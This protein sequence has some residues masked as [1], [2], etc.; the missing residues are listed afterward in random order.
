MTPSRRLLPVFALLAASAC[1]S[2][3]APFGGPSDVAGAV[4]LADVDVPDAARPFLLT[5]YPTPQRVNYGDA[6]LPLAGAKV[7]DDKSP[8]FDAV[9]GAQGLD[10]GWA[11]LPPEGYVLA[12][13]A[14]GGRVVVLEAARDAAGRRWADEAL[15][16][17]TYETPRGRFA[18]ECRV[19]DAPA[20]PLRGEKR[21]QAWETKYRANFAWGAKDDP[22]FAGRAMT[23]VYAPGI[24]L[25]ATAAGAARAL[26]FFRPWQDRGVRLFA[27]KFDD[28]GFALTPEAEFVHGRFAP[29]LV[30]YMRRVREGLRRR[31]PEARLYFLP[32]TYWWSDPRLSV[33]AV[34]LRV[35]GGIDADVGIVLTGPEIVSPTIDAAGLD[36]A[37]RAFGLTRTGA[38]IYDNLG[39]DGDWGPLVGHGADLAKYADGVFGE[40]G[41]PVNRLTRLDWLWN[42]IDYDPEKSWRRAVYELA[43]PR[44]FERLLALCRALRDGANK[45]DVTALVDAFAAAPDGAWRGPIAKPE[46][47]ALVRGDVARIE[48]SAATTSRFRPAQPSDD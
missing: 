4:R 32:Q 18:R 13:A 11:D 29:A 16:Q 14:R 1:A 27:V 41:T 12:V 9:L 24:P 17:I 36:A 30:D 34:S 37:R 2:R 5:I 23:A 45:D 25:D 20:F 48:R 46:L 8:D 42:P 26:A 33:F 6:L 39:R 43:G 7:V 19:L 44:G 3:V 35:A 28:E 15:S 47:V 21:P 38:L 31:D 22:D 40:R 10:R